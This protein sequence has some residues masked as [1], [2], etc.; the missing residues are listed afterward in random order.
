MSLLSTSLSNVRPNFCHRYLVAVNV[1]GFAYAGFQ[2]FDLALS[3]A[4]GKH[5][6]SYHMR[7]HFNFSMDQASSTIS[8]GVLP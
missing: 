6:L 4:T 8:T 5:F 7:Y 3:L 2:A 1:I